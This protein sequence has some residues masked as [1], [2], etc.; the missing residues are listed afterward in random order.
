MSF[1][2]GALRESEEELGIRPEE[3]DVLGEIGPPE[4]NL[5]GDMCVWPYVVCIR[6]I[7]E[8]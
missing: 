6:C 2:D 5:R 8:L 1:L 4:E 3:I 7:F